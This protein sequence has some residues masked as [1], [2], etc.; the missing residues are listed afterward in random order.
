VTESTR[1]VEAPSVASTTA[2]AA[3]CCAGDG[4]G[5]QSGCPG[6]YGKTCVISRRMVVE[7]ASIPKIAQLTPIRRPETS[8]LTVAW[9]T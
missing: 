4:S 8:V 5:A 1:N 3:A 9:Y 7:Y 6:A 2:A